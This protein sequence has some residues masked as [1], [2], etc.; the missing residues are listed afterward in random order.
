MCI[1]DS[2]NICPNTAVT[3]RIFFMFAPRLSGLRT[4]RSAMTLKH[5]NHDGKAVRQEGESLW[6]RLRFGILVFVIL[7]ALIGVYVWAHFPA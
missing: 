4:L 5:P 3:A 1:R 2:P 6:A 7:A